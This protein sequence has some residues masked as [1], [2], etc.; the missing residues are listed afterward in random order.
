MGD[1]YDQCPR[2]SDDLKWGATSCHCG[3][4][5]RKRGEERG[6]P[7]RVPVQCAHED[8]PDDAT[9]RI[10]TPTGWANLCRGHYDAYYARVA[11]SWCVERGLNTVEQ[12]RAYIRERFA[13]DRTAEISRDWMYQIG[14][15]GVDILARSG[16]AVLEELRERGIV[17]S[18]NR[19]V[20]PAPRQEAA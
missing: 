3:W 2:C 17:D 20:A 18:Q 9:I 6:L 19:I 16:A 11:R 5:K 15:A 10:K 8:C 7:P 1:V 4:K 13:R 14:Q 12:M